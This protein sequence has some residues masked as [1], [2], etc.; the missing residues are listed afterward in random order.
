[1]EGTLSG[2]TKTVASD[3]ER[4]IIFGNMSDA[5]KASTYR[6]FKIYPRCKGSIRI[7]QYIYGSFD[8]TVYKNGVVV[9][10]SP[11]SSSSRYWSFDVDVDK[12]DVI[13]FSSNKETYGTN[14]YISLKYDYV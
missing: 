10:V 4:D 11:S 6:T 2:A 3:T 13:T 9:G 5:V 1:M 12:F 14:I 7:Y 8:V